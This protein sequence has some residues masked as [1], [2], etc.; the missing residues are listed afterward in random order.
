VSSSSALVP[1]EAKEAASQPAGNNSFKNPSYPQRTHFG[2]RTQL[3]ET[4]HT[5]EEKIRGA[6]GKL[7]ALGDQPGR[8]TYERLFHQ[9]LGARDQ[10]AEAAARI[11]LEAG[12]LYEDDRERFEAAAE[13]LGRLF[14]K[15]DCVKE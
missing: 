14:Q 15:W 11:P 9:M 13:A 10:M 7:A 12:V 8:S 1:A 6:S 2:E 3:E 4:L 5:W